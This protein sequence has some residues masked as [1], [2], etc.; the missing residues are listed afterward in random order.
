MANRDVQ[1]NRSLFS[2]GFVLA[3]NSR[4]PQSFAD[5]IFCSTP[6]K[7]FVSDQNIPER[8]PPSPPWDWSWR[9]LPRVDATQCVPPEYRRIR[10]RSR[11]KILDLR[12]APGRW[13]QFG[14]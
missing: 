8:I 13:P 5:Y 14:R 1:K 6:K 9:R 11:H 3:L 2:F 7:N 4:E 12:N 10:R